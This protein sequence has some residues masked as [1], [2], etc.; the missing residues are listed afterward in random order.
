MSNFQ[1]T[2]IEWIGCIPTNW[3][4][5]RLQWH[6]EEI[7][8]KNSPIKTR[9]ILSLTNKLGVVPYS[10]KGNQGNV[11]KENYNEYKIAYPDTIVANSM[12]ILIGSVGYCNYLGCVSPVY[13][14][15]KA[16]GNN[17]LKYFNYLF[18]TQQFQKELRRYANG[19]LE[20]RLRVSSSD[21]LKRE[22]PIPSFEEQTKI[23]NI[24]ENKITQIGELIANQEKQI[25][26]LNEYKQ[27]TITRAVTQGIS[28]NATFKET[29]I[30]W[31]GKIPESWKTIKLKYTSWL[32]GRIGWDGLTSSEYVDEGPHLITGT[33]FANGE[34]N[35][36][37]C[38]HISE[39]RFKEDELLHIKED[40]LLIT[41]DGTIGKLA[42][43]K[44]CPEKV[45]L[46]SGVMIIR[47]TGE[48]KYFNK[49]LY[50][51]LQSKQFNLWYELSQG[52][53]STIRHL[54]QGQFY[55][56][57]FTY[58]SLIEQKAISDYLDLKC[59]DID[60]LISMRN[61]KI[62]KLN[63]YKTSLIFEYVTG[64]KQ[65]S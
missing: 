34:I 19:I 37:T 48:L 7:V 62:D 13:Y 6:L 5:E 4:L 59:A 20:I 53:N 1:K 61:S 28:N 33:D 12:N 8:E 9:N 54:Y 35:W 43:V 27:S 29:N 10:E 17:N 22:V 49:Y 16:K 21:I 36:S 44:N 11:A 23:V 47:N 15:Y 60:T 58:P 39:E 46:N 55:D 3:K 63:E 64:K 32:K 40:D 26:V 52:G 31:I 25:D 51:V 14:V 57:E 65:V 38:V 24:L 30:A 42:I 45:S 56:F 50:Y 41:K 2:G 18:Q